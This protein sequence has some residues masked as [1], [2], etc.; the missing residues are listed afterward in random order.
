VIGGTVTVLIPAIPTRTRMLN[1]ALI[2]ALNQM[3]LPDQIIVAMDHD[4]LGAAGNRNRALKSV[5]TE[6]VAFLDDDDEFLPQHLLVLLQNTDKGDVL[7]T[8]CTV[9]GPQGQE[10]PPREEWGRFG[11]P[12]DGFLL[13]KKSYLPVTSMV[14]MRFLREMDEPFKAPLDSDYDDWGMYLQLLDAG[15]RFSHIAQKTWTWNHWGGNSSG[16]SDRW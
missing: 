4:R 12:F 9:L 2:S 15:A 8:G 7:Y 1:R 14:R 16:R 11:K 5:Q 10:I 3:R 13:R 6:W